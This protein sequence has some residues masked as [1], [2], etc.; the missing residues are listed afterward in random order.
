VIEVPQFGKVYLGEVMLQQYERQVTMLRL[1]L[2]SPSG[3]VT[4]GPTTGGG[5]TGF[6]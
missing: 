2:G 1:E 6:P 4:T 5:G 3:G